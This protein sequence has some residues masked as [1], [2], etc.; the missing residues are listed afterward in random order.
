MNK[1]KSSLIYIVAAVALAGA[2]LSAWRLPVA[3]FLK[4][5]VS[6][7][8]RG[9]KLPAPQLMVGIRCGG[10]YA[11]HTLTEDELSTVLS[12]HRAWLESG[13]K[14]DDERRANL[15]RAKV[16][17]VW[18]FNKVDLRGAILHQADLRG[19][20]FMGTNLRGG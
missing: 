20:E 7:R 15:C 4:G 9:D 17:V 2:S 5:L 11:A 14:P 3:D 8:V 6:V 10:P 18:I 12:N 13:A 1:W 16:P 19:A